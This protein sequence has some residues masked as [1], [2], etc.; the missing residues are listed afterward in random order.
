[1][2]RSSRIGPAN[3]SYFKR[4]SWRTERGEDEED[5]SQ[6]RVRQVASSGEGRGRL[7]DVTGRENGIA[8]HDDNARRR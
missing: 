1:M 8:L 2:E 5:E 3:A 6:R 7:G 4:H